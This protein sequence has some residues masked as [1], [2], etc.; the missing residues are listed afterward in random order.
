[1]ISSLPVDK[2]AATPEEEASA[3]L[4]AATMSVIPARPLSL[5]AVSTRRTPT[6][7]PAPRTSPPLRPR[8]AA[9]P[10]PTI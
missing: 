3:S 8:P 10:L 1:M 7:P 2:L 4:A 9:Q 6:A 5:P